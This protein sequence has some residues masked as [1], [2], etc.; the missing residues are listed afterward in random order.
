MAVSRT[1]FPEMP[2]Y[3]LDWQLWHARRRISSNGYAL[4]TVDVL[5]GAHD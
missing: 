4:V 2:V 3:Q 1:V 5:C